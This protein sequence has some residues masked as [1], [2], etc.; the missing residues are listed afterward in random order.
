[1]SEFSSLNA[2]LTGLYAQKRALDVAGQ[3]ITNANTDGYSRQRVEMS[4]LQGP[5]VPSIYSTW[6]GTGAGVSVDS[7]S[8]LRD[9]FLEQR[10][11]IEHGQLSAYQTRTGVLHQV[12]DVFGEPGDQSIQAQ[13]SAFWNGWDDVANHPD[14]LAARQQLLEKSRTVAG[15]FNQVGG[16]LEAQWTSL[17]E[18]LG[19]TVENVNATAQQVAVLNAAIQ[20]GTQSGSDVNDLAD[21]RD[22]LVQQLAQLSGATVRG[23]SDGMV[24]V[25]LAGG[26]LVRGTHAN[27]LAVSGVTSFDAVP[28]PTLGGAPAVDVVW[29]EGG[30]S[31][32]LAAGTA[33]GQLA[34]I[35]TDIPGYRYR[36]DTLAQQLATT[37][38]AAH[39]NGFD[40]NGNAGGPVFT[41]TT[42]RSLTMALT[43]PDQIAANSAPGSLDGAAAQTVGEL[44]SASDGVDAHYRQLVVSLGVDAQTADRQQSIEEAVVQHLDASR[45]SIAGVNLDEEMTNMVAFQHAYEASSRFLSAIDEALDTL[46]NHTGMVG[47]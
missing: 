26:A 2:A 16:G 47:R 13:L 23:G 19:A 11:A 41:G 36:L 8:R 38:N 34:A 46:V 22:Q 7:I 3:N 44:G 43:S 6:A 10:A 17:R 35:N 18:Q 12:E 32:S 24:D 37:V 28:D 39:A 14:D 5:T 31:A 40:Q 9:S 45:E 33:G 21:Q 25:D 29:A 30:Y 20:R 42:A 27:A 15:Q 1:M 4:A